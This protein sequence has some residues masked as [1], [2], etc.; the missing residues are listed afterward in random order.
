[1]RIVFDFKRFDIYKWVSIVLGIGIP[2]LFLGIELGTTGLSYSLSNVCLPTGPQAFVTWFV[3]LLTLS[4]VSTIILIATILYCLWKYS[5]SAISAVR[6]GPSQPTHRSTQSTDTALAGEAEPGQRPSRRAVR[7]RKRV[8]WARIK[9]VL[10]LQ[11]RTILLAFIILNETVYFAIVF[12]QQ[13]GASM[14]ASHGL[15]PANR[16]WSACLIV[17]KGDKT[18]CLYQSSGLGLSKPRV[19]AMLLLFSVS[20]YLK[21]RW[22]VT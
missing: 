13:T 16:E 2:I 9:K 4:A 14:A 19:V 6:A 7:R 17:T 11:W 22:D 3:W 1:M 8:E 18:A 21:L 12:V 20:A 15:T 5:L 10:I